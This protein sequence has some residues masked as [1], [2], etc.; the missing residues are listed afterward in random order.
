MHIPIKVDYGVRALVHLARH[1]EDG[2]VRANEIARWTAIPEPYLAQVLLTLSKRG[3]VRSQ[4][5]PQGGHA[6]AQNASEI[7]LSIVMES[8]G[9]TE[10]L[11]GCLDDISRCIHVPACAQREVWRS[12]E[13]AVYN[14]L[15]STTIDDLAKRTQAMEVAQRERAP[16]AAVEMAV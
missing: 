1:S 6:L 11:V 9:G 16:V 7:R 3:L 12:V 14:I 13:E 10:N 2:P 4:R 8:L 5:G 15:D